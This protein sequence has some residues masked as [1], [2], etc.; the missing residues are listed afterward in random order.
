MVRMRLI[1]RRRAGRG[2]AG[3]LPGVARRFLQRGAHEIGKFEVLEEDVEH[4][5]L[6]H[7]EFEIVF[8]FAGIRRLL[9]ARRRPRPWA[10]S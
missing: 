9:A 8:A 5:V 4:F 6:R 7:R 1:W 3:A 2:D 10:A